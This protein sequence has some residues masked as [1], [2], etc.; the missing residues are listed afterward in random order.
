MKHCTGCGSTLDIDMFHRRSRSK[1][2]LRSLCKRCVMKYNQ[3]HKVE[4]AVSKIKR[5]YNLTPTQYNELL[6]AGCAICGSKEN[7]HIDHDHKCCPYTKSHK[8]CGRCVRGVLCVDHNLG[9]GRFHDDTAMLGRAIAY[10]EG[11]RMGGL[12]NDD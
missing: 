3:S 8:T 10:L 9:L 1:D 7:L 5:M 6:A 11:D 12:V 4:R 2:G